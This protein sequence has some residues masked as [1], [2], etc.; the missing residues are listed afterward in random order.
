MAR[1]EGIDALRAEQTARD[2]AAAAVVRRAFDIGVAALLLLLT[3]PL[4]AL[5]ALAVLLQS[6]RP[7]FFGQMRLGKGGRP[8]RCWKLRTMDVDAQERLERDAALRLRHLSGGFKLPTES[9]PRVTRPGRWLRRA[10]LD[11]LP[12]FVNVM[13]GHMSIVGPRPVVPEELPVYGERASDLLLVKPGLIGAWTALGR[14]R[15]PY[16]ERARLEL[17]YARH[18]TLAWDVRL[19]L[20]ALPAVLAGEPEA[21]EVAG[22]RS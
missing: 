18:R 7:V 20:R 3:S 5:G 21:D 10:R 22:D 9:D 16:P 14:G 13:L 4:L 17:E 1:N 19:L 12:Q 2:S 6:G 11:E 15:P 8:F